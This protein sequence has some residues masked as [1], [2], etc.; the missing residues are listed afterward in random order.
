MLGD[1][2]SNFN[3]DRLRDNNYL[4]YYSQYKINGKSHEIGA[5]HCDKM[6]GTHLGQYVRR[7]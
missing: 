5:E 2:I 3:K 4:N 1:K 7:V 6:R